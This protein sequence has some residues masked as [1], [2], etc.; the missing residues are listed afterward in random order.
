MYRRVIWAC[1]VAS[2]VIGLGVAHADEAADINKI[3]HDGD[4]VRLLAYLKA[5]KP[6][7]DA[8]IWRGVT[9]LGQA[10]NEK[11]PEIARILIENGADVNAGEA[12][13]PPRVMWGG[14][15]ALD[16]AAWMDSVAVAEVLIDHNAD[17]NRHGAEHFAPLIV[18]AARGSEGVAKLLLE[19]GANP[20]VTDVDGNSPLLEAAD[21]GHQSMVEL[22]IAHGADMEAQAPRGANQTALGKALVRG[23][24]ATAAW[25]LA[26]H[27]RCDYVDAV[28]Q[29]TLFMAASR[30]WDDEDEQIRIMGLLIKCGS[31]VNAEIPEQGVR[32]PVS[33]TVLWQALRG[34][35]QK[36]AA[37]LVS[38]GARVSEGPSNSSDFR[39]A[40]ISVHDARLLAQLVER[41]AQIDSRDQGGM[42]PFLAAV[43]ANNED[44]V[45]FLLDHGV[46]INEHDN[47]GRNALHFLAENPR[48]DS[49]RLFTTLLARGANTDA[50]TVPGFRSDP[51]GVEV[52]PL[53]EAAFNNEPELVRLLIDH[54]ANVNAAT[55][56]GDT[57]LDIAVL[58]EHIEIAQTL[59]SSGAAENASG[60]QPSTVLY[61]A[62]A[63]KRAEAVR[64]L[65][66][67]HFSL[68]TK[69][70]ARSE[71][72]LHAAARDG[73]I[74]LL[75]LLIGAGANLAAVDR[76]GRTPLHL[77]VSSDQTEAA[78][79]LL[80]HGASVAT[81]DRSGFAPIYY[82]KSDKMTSLLV[83]YHAK[84]P[85]HSTLEGDALA[86][87]SVV[88]H[89]NE[90]RLNDIL[91]DQVD[92]S[93]LKQSPIDDWD[94]D[95]LRWV[96]ARFSLRQQKSEFVVGF[97]QDHL[98][99][100]S[101]LSDDKVEK[102]ICQFVEGPPKEKIVMAVDPKLCS[103]VMT[104]KLKYPEYDEAVA[105]EPDESSTFTSVGNVAAKMD[106]ENNGTTDWIVDVQYSS[107]HG[108]GCDESYPGILLSD[109]KALDTAR[110]DSLAKL[111]PSCGSEAKPFSFD[112]HTYIEVVPP[113]SA[114]STEHKIVKIDRGA[115]TDM[116][117]ISTHSTYTISS[118]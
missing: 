99:Y 56:A 110:T 54:G 10:A 101:R 80:A 96:D 4:T 3:I 114:H 25:L 108:M 45:A 14:S 86:C 27:A 31:D 75:D 76:M 70:T 43:Q 49:S 60:A 88:S 112:G 58:A 44:A 48:V 61:Q 7:M 111:L 59:L 13:D 36:V 102:V 21:A 55:T 50:T 72:A 12:A 28:R 20:N 32:P 6:N 71:T 115:P 51:A 66:D 40:V 16:H 57:A 82:A 18:A 117:T 81:M 1:L 116:C 17:L 37:W 11:Q 42:T 53:H 113:I 69:D 93:T 8:P 46:D 84:L 109:K 92:G 78:A 22:L 95:T 47:L 85:F 73:S 97:S 118:P 26:H 106:L 62:V 91:G 89:A 52:T 64:F 103:A 38:Q 24:A 39:K 41:G 19:K 74:E 100:V 35:E 67:H 83:E 87:A 5:V 15:T 94:G 68:E 98:R 30:K 34:G 79:H 33:H 104:G 65:V 23:H 77:A 105:L 29:T 107:S 9:M 90:A 63:W 2:L